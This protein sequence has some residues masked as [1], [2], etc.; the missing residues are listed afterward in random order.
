MTGVAWASV[1]GVAWDRVRD[2]GW[3][4]VTVDQGT[5]VGDVSAALG[6]MLELLSSMIS[7]GGVEVPV[8]G[9]D[10]ELTAGSV[11]IIRRAARRI[12]DLSGVAWLLSSDLHDEFWRDLISHPLREQI[13]AI[14]AACSGSAANSIASLP[15]QEVGDYVRVRARQSGVLGPWAEGVL[16]R[17]TLGPSILVERMGGGYPPDLAGRRLA[18]LP[19]D[20]LSRSVR[21]LLSPDGERGLRSL[22]LAWTMDGGARLAED[23]LSSSGPD[24]ASS[25]AAAETKD[26]DRIGRSY[27]VGSALQAALDALDPGI[28]LRVTDREV[29]EGW[30][31]RR[32]PRRHGYWATLAVL[33]LLDSLDA[34]AGMPPWATEVPASLRRLSVRHRA[35]IG[36]LLIRC[37]HDLDPLPDVVGA[38]L[39]GALSAAL[40]AVEGDR[41]TAGIDA[42]HF[43]AHH[44]RVILA[45]SSCAGGDLSGALRA[46]AASASLS[47]IVVDLDGVSSALRS[48]GRSGDA[49]AVD[50]L[51]A[52]AW[53]AVTGVPHRSPTDDQI[54]VFESLMRAV[55]RDPDGWEPFQSTALRALYSSCRELRIVVIDPADPTKPNGD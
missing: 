34:R 31:R 49:D 17:G 36:D 50:A 24:P 53:W 54:G 40:R 2:V 38:V 11:E 27:L 4:L 35:L 9:W 33:S 19:D 15:D 18:I 23:R 39:A 32:A 16:I 46:L 45:A 12:V 44:R 21:P 47:S 30:L 28:E 43:S 55:A 14:V 25:S 51:H 1:R 42:F 29:L 52:A 8:G 20:Q 13:D 7:S 3:S 5:V 26:D 22:A 6:R 41:V 37:R 48:A 10:R